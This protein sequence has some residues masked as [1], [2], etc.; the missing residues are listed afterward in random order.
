M[1][2]ILHRRRKENPLKETILHREE[3]KG[4]EYTCQYKKK[5]G[6]IQ[7]STN[8]ERERFLLSSGEVDDK[9]DV[10]LVL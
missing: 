8:F 5:I 9:P 3:K 6:V 10:E 2:E 4:N 7:R 1:N